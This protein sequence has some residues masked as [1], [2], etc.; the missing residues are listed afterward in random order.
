MFFLRNLCPECL[1]AV[2]VKL[3]L[4]Y[5]CG[6]SLCCCF[7]IPLGTITSQ[8]ENVFFKWINL[9]SELING[10]VD[11]N[12]IDTFDTV[13][14][15]TTFLNSLPWAEPVIILR[16]NRLTSMYRK[17]FVAD[18]LYHVE[19]NSNSLPWKDLVGDPVVGVVRAGLKR[20]SVGYGM[21]CAMRFLFVPSSGV[22]SQANKILKALVSDDAKPLVQGEEEADL[23]SDELFPERSFYFLSTNSYA[24]GRGPNLSLTEHLKAVAPLLPSSDFLRRV[25][26]VIGVHVRLVR[27]ASGQMFKESEHARLSVDDLF[28]VMDCAKAL[29]V[30]RKWRPDEVAYILFSDSALMRRHALK[31]F[32]KQVFVNPAAAISHVDRFEGKASD[33]LQNFE[34]TV[35]EMLVLSICDGLTLTY[36]GFGEA[37][38][39]IGLISEDVTAR[40]FQD[41]YVDTDS[42]KPCQC[43][44][45]GEK[46]IACTLTSPCWD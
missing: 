3:L 25:K 44:L 41:P 35:A 26:H 30:K 24:A 32:Q 4:C 15:P 18:L 20:M 38:Q 10:V 28:S 37:A 5:A 14:W 43:Y 40:Y 33:N 1:V 46:T 11:V 29:A 42:Q 23:F 16:S 12:D 39:S 36:S 6:C 9:D 2:C 7:S 19:S 21:G 17:R 8:F 27:D 22:A 45:P 31:H 13:P 34:S